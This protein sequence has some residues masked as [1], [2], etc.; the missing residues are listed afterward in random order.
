[1]K[2]T[3][4]LYINHPGADGPESKASVRGF[5][6]INEQISKFKGS[7]KCFG[8]NNKP[9]VLKVMVTKRMRGGALRLSSAHFQ[10]RCGAEL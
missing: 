8:L 7:L 4:E 9:S 1:M 6:Q 2:I 10:T 3:V 5:V